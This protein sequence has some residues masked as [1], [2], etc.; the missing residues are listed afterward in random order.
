MTAGYPPT[1]PRTP[2]RPA[3]PPPATA[4]PARAE[5]RPPRCAA[6]TRG[7]CLDVPNSAHDQR[8]PDAAVGLQRRRQPAVDADQRQGTAGLRRQVPRR[9]EQGHGERHQGDHLGLQRRH[10]PAVEPQLRR[11]HH[12]RPVRAVPG[13]QRLRHRQRHPR[14]AVVVHRREQPEVDPRLSRKPDGF[15]REGCGPVVPC[16]SADGPERSDTRRP[17]GSFTP[18]SLSPTSEDRSMKKYTA[19]LLAATVRRAGHG[20]R[21]ARGGDHRRDTVPRRA[22]RRGACLPAADA[23]RGLDHLGCR[24][25]VGKQLPGLPVEP[26]GGRGTHLGLRR[27]GRNGSMSDPDNEGHSGW[28]IDQI[29]GITDSVA[30]PLPAQRGHPGDRHQRPERQLPGRHRRR[31]AAAR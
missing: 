25:L 18:R 27:S 26:V 6:A 5:A 29:A 20:C 12:R 4:P 15:S 22:R 9:R 28:R 16:G 8:H 24:K 11:H 17:S 14:P 23:A 19:P 3:S 10:Q 30:G 1:P 13:R 2:Y 31:P 7:R 21:T